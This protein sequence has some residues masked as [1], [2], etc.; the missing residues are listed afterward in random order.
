VTEVLLAVAA[1]FGAVARYATDTLCVRALGPRWPWGTF[2]VNV[3]GALVL[4][5][6]TGL[7]LHH[8]LSRDTKAIFGTGFCGAFTTYSTFSYE[9]VRLAQEQRRATAAGYVALTLIG[10]LGAAAG[11][12]G[13]ALL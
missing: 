9:A 11:G 6:L 5:L 13:L 7:M 8:G 10:G 4:G 1:A 12:L 2:T 3:L